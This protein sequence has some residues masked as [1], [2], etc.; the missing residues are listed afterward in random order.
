MNYVILST[1]L[2]IIAETYL[3]LVEKESKHLFFFFFFLAK[4]FEF[5]LW[6]LSLLLYA[7]FYDYVFHNGYS[8]LHERED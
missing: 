6:H 7:D 4:G 8:C 5:F 2:K 3:V 1:Y